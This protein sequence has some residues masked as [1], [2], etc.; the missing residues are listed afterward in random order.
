MKRI[1]TNVLLIFISAFI[2]LSLVS[3]QEKKSERKVKVIIAD[4]DGTVA[5]LDTTFTGDNIP[6][7]IILENGKVVYFADKGTLT[8]TGENGN[9][10]VTCTMDDKDAKGKEEKVII[11]SGDGTQWTVKPSSGSKEHVFVMSD[12]EGDDKKAIRVRVDSDNDTETDMTKYV[13]AKDGVVVTV[14]SNDEAKAKAVLDA[15]EAKLDARA[16][17]SSNQDA[18]KSETKKSVKK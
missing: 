9:I 13:I 16:D 7:S 3:G 10:Y 2:P 15:V 14:E 6:D 11:M 8:T 5:R 4:K 17:N 12:R 1:F 18:V